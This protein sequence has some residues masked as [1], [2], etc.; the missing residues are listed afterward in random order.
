MRIAINGNRHQE[1][2]FSEIDSLISTLVRRGDDVVLAEPFFNYLADNLGP[3]F[4]LG[5]IPR[6]MSEKTHAHHA[7][8]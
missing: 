1:G 2:H 6:E 7:G 5:I 8:S 3:R 4:A